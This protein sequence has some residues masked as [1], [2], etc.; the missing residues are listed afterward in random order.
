VSETRKLAAILVSD[1]V[2]Y[3]RL[4]GADEDRIL[5]RLRTLRSDLIDPTIAGSIRSPRSARSRASVPSSSA[6]AS[7]DDGYV[8]L[9]PDL[10]Y[11]YG[12]YGPFVPKE[13][14][15]GDVRAILGPLMATTGKDKVISPCRSTNSRTGYPTEPPPRQCKQCGSITHCGQSDSRCCL[16]IGAGASFSIRTHRTQ[17]SYRHDRRRICE[18]TPPS[19]DASFGAGRR[20]HQPAAQSRR[21]HAIGD[22]IAVPRGPCTRPS[23]R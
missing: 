17:G 6:S 19:I 1:V 5:A 21:R 2:G 13:V 18:L 8:V 16:R 3:S 7:P 9:L 10:F 22:F 15:A 4:A 12:P 23:T 14:F 20:D 11:R